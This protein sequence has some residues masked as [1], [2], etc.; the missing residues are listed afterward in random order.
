MN[1]KE[2]IKDDLLRQYMMPGEG[3]NAPQGFTSK[4]MTRVQLGTS[5]LYTR[6]RNLV[7]WISS[8][9]ATVL[10]V[11]AIILPGN[12]AGSITDP[13]VKLADKLDLSFLK[14]IS[15]TLF[16]KLTVPSVVLYVI[17]GLFVL[18]IFDRALSGMFRRR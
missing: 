12:E 5:V 17:F 14:S 6:K 9:L 2:K 7:P 18:A 13:L 16:S 8:V 15:L 4:V 3:E 1:S 11:M 10:L